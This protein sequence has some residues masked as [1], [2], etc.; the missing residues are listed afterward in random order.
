MWPSNGPEAYHSGHCRCARTHLQHVALRAMEPVIT[1][2]SSPAA[3][4]CTLA[5]CGQKHSVWIEQRERSVR[6]VRVA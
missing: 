3:R 1:M 5:A 6:V 4:P 2:I